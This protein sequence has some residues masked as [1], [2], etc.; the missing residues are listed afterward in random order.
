MAPR[1]KTTQQ[2]PKHIKIDPSR[3]VARCITIEVEFSMSVD[4]IEDEADISDSVRGAL[5]ELRRFGSA[6]ITEDTI[7]IEQE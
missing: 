6:K 1:K 5:D 3:I 7:K 4:G 2:K